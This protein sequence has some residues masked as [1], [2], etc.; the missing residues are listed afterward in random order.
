MGRKGEHR[1][2]SLDS[3]RVVLQLRLFWEYRETVG[4]EWGHEEGRS[5]EG[6][7]WRSEGDEEIDRWVDT[8]GLIIFC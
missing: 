4:V 1:G 6:T 2:R 8:W 7:E 5:C 3:Q